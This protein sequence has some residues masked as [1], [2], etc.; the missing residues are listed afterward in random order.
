MPLHA[1]IKQIYENVDDRSYIIRFLDYIISK[2]YKRITFTVKGQIAIPLITGVLENIKTKERYHSLEEFY[3]KITG[4]K[5]HTRNVSLLSNI[6]I[7]EA[8]SVMRI[9]CNY[10]E[11]DILNFFDQKYR[12][13]LFYRDVRKRLREYHDIKA[14][15]H[16]TLFWNGD[17]YELNHTELTCNDTNKLY[18]TYKLLEAFENKDIEGLYYG[19]EKE[20]YLITDK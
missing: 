7:T 14:P 3:T 15:G 12:T 13:F 6:Y 4:E 5:V 16:I 17:E 19:N 9:I 8:Y 18:I 1:Y 2:R 11:T 10:N 20:Q